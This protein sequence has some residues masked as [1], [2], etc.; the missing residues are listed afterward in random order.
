M[1]AIASRLIRRGHAL[2]MPR[3][4]LSPARAGE[5]LFVIG[6][7]RSGNTLVRRILVASDQIYIPPET[8]VLGDLIELW[9]RAALLTWR[10]RVWL[11]C[12][13]F[14]K[15]KHWPTFGLPNLD[16]FAAEAMQL[17]P[18]K[19]RPLIEAFF[20]YLARKSG[21]TATR[22][23]DKTPW[24]TY[25]LPAIAQMF[26]RARYLW[27][28]RDGRDVALSY[29]KAGLIAD[30]EGA[31]R[32]WCDANAACARLARW[33]PNVMQIRYEDLVATPE[34][35]F[36]KVFDWAGLDFA[37]R[38]LTADVGSLG[39]VEQLSHH[40]SV[41]GAISTSS[42]GTWRSAVSESELASVPADFHRWLTELGYA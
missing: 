8:F 33:S 2:A 41:T 4:R 5:P 1:S 22:W 40:A 27:L 30:F 19:L 25:H 26:P 24:N 36:A 3:L 38:M 15:H 31:A 20:F 18:R 12:A 42:I 29:R 6:S 37:P 32:R 35:A 34:T 11:F 13:H 16:E 7:G 21:S 23:G 39:D 28:I 10:E 14:E 9:P 17:R